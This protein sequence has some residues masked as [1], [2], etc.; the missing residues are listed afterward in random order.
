[1]I[2]DA[3]TGYQFALM[4]QSGL[5][6]VDA[7]RYF[8]PETDPNDLGPLV[9]EW[10]SNKFVL[11]ATR[12]LQGKAFQEMTLEEKIKCTLDLHYSQM[13]YFLYSHNYSTLNSQDKLKADTCR[14]A[15]ESKAAGTAGKMTP[16]T[17]FWAD[18]RKND[19]LKLNAR[20]Q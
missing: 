20:I 1:M 9:K 4:L 17:E 13:A 18:L 10:I 16:L 11:S 8:Y 5:P 12:K 2:I 7:L 6:H 15:L 14:L 3:E 19:T